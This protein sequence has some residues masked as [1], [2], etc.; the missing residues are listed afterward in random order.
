MTL[1]LVSDNPEPKPERFPLTEYADSLRALADKIEAGDCGDVTH[2][3][4]IIE[5]DGGLE[6]CE[7]G[8]RSNPH[9]LMGML[10]AAK[11]MA[12]AEALDD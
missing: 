6:I 12:F 3:A 1:K 10:E 7:A 4:T 11:L 8:E 9:L 2:M 5:Y